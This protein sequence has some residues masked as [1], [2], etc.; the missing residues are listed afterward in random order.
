MTPT[1]SSVL[2]AGGSGLI[3][4]EIVRTLLSGPPTMTVHALVR[5]S[6]TG[7]A[8]PRLRL[9]TVDFAALPALPAADAAYC[10]LGTTI[11]VAGS[12]Q[13]FKAVDLD[14]VLAFAQAARRAG[15]RRFAVV[16]SLGANPRSGSF[17]SR[18]KGEMESALAACGF[19]S[20][21]IARPSLLA[22]DRASLG[23]P[24]RLAERWTLALT[25]PLWPLMP[26]AWRPIQADVV[27]RALVAA[28]A[29]ARPG[30]SIIESGELQRTG[31]GG[32]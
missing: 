31:R 4:R 21:I 3:G 19:D 29:G 6:P 17:Y 28:V 8:N 10:A 12:Q 9:L 7:P 14:A 16:S 15:V 20:L 1:A 26:S 30:T 24:A 22:G 23:Q 27:A 18:I 25:A 32:T 5:R 2:V 11:K 13:A